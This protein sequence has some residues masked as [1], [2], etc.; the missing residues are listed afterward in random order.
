MKNLRNQNRKTEYPIRSLHDFLLDVENELKKF[1]SVSIL[2]VIASMFILLDLGRFIFVLLHIS[3][4]IPRMPPNYPGGPTLLF[5]L[6]LTILAL[7][8]LLYSLHALIGQNAFLRRWG[9]K[10]EEVRALEQKLLEGTDEKK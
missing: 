10:F 7:A 1:R 2:G 3:G 6:A 8:C 4:N 5:D 9:E